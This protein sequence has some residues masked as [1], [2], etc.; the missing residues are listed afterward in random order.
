VSSLLLSFATV[1]A[2]EDTL[3][4]TLVRCIVAVVF[5]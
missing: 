2:L 1:L 4:G 5:F 3:I